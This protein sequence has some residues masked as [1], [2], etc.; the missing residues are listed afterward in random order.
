MVVLF[1]VMLLRA[2][3]FVAALLLGYCI[4]KIAL[5]G[6]KKV[7]TKSF[8][9][10]RQMLLM[11]VRFCARVQLFSY[12]FQWICVKGKPTP[13]Q[14]APILVSNH[15][16]FAD[17]LFIF[18][19]HLPVIVTAHENLTMPVAGAIMKAMQMIVVNRDLPDSRRNASSAIKRKAMCNN[20]S[21]VM[22]FLEA[23]T[24]NGKALVSF[25]AG[26]FT[27]SY[28]VQPMLMQWR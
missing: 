9:T 26:A 16:T 18:F 23:T 24:T 25:K 8:P 19:R 22:I 21:H 5:L 4:T 10:W 7:L 6:A 17:P 27:P 15:V 13:R 28:A 14:E 12:G 11:P 20:W 1:P 3:L 2:V